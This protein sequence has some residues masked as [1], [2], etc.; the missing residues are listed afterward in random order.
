MKTIGTVGILGAFLLLGA[1][2]SAQAT[3]VLGSDPKSISSKARSIEKEYVQGL[4]E[5]RVEHSPVAPVMEVQEVE[6]IYAV[7]THSVE[8]VEAVNSD[9]AV[10]TSSYMST[11]QMRDQLKVGAGMAVGGALGVLGINMELNF[12]DADGVVI[13]FGTGPGYNSVQLAWKHAFEGDYLAPY[14]T[15]GYSRWYNSHGGEEIKNSDILDRVLTR[16]EKE[17]GRFGTDFLN[18]TLGL[19]YNQ[20]SGPLA[21]LSFYGEL[22]TMWEVK[23]SMLLP[24]GSAGVVYYF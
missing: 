5:K 14:I 4:Q 9:S 8:T 24:N 18:A 19:Q 12:E 20:L 1:M 21:G 11:L 17:S 3:V 10:S 15:A 7:P 13:G 6:T 2:S 23:R 22:V 16:E